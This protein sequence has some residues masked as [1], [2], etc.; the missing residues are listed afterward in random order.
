MTV[1]ISIFVPIA[2]FIAVILFVIR[3]LLED[4]RKREDRARKLRA[5]KS[6]LAHETEKNHYAQSRLFDVIADIDEHMEQSERYDFIALDEFGGHIAYQ[7]H[8]L[9]DGAIKNLTGQPIPQLHSCQLERWLPVVAELDDEFFNSMME[10]NNTMAELQHFRTSLIQYLLKQ[11]LGGM[12]LLQGFV[13]FALN[14]QQ[15]MEDG[16]ANFYEACTGN[17]KIEARIR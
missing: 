12:N 8:E 14:H 13:K 2:G 5:A 3:E 16:V 7:R 4:K 10:F 1:E 11:E 9:D 17:K 6:L 15:E